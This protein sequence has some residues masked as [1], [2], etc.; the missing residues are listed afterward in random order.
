LTVPHHMRSGVEFYTC[1]ITLVL[2]D[3]DFEFQIFPIKGVF[4]TLI[5]PF[6]GCVVV[7]V[8]VTDPLKQV[9]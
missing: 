7:L 3:I 9:P 4:S 1:G 2:K 8:I 6:M 5:D